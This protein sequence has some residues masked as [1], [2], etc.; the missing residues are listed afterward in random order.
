MKYLKLFESFSSIIEDIKDIFI[1]SNLD[2]IDFLFLEN[3]NDLEFYIYVKSLSDN[4]K[5]NKNDIDNLNRCI[6]LIQYEYNSR[7]Y[8]KEVLFSLYYHGD[9]NLYNLEK[10]DKYVP[11]EFDDNDIVA[12][13][14]DDDISIFKTAFSVIKFTFSLNIH[15]KE[16]INY[17]IIK[18]DIKDLFIDTNFN[19]KFIT[20]ASYESDSL[21]FLPKLDSDIDFI[22]EKNNIRLSIFN[23]DYD[24][25]DIIH[26]MNRMMYEYEGFFFGRIIANHHSKI[27]N[28]KLSVEL[29]INENDYIKY[30]AYGELHRF[31]DKI[32][33]MHIKYK[34]KK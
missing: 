14:D 30:K 7:L 19:T 17:D 10:I 2:K 23:I 22:L 31:T 5:L 26:R 18:E 34:L 9:L 21:T 28:N 32:R 8:K 1:D 12:K 24:L 15:I 3:K 11:I 27:F 6:N 13:F 25:E 4:I 20:K 29:K 33:Y 16:N